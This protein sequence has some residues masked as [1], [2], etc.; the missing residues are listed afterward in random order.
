MAENEKKEVYPI[1]K[2]LLKD[3][4]TELKDQI[5]KGQQTLNIIQQEL[6]KL[7]L[8]HNKIQAKIELLDE[9]ESEGDMTKG[10]DD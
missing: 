8:E 5:Q 6:Q 3:R 1:R 4:Q 9:L 7:V 10:E 2:K